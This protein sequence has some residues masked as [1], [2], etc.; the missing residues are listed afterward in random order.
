MEHHRKLACRVYQDAQ[1]KLKTQCP[2]CFA[3]HPILPATAPPSRPPPRRHAV[4]RSDGSRHALR[5]H[6]P[7]TDWCTM[8]AT[9]SAS[10][11]PSAS[12][13]PILVTGEHQ[14]WDADAPLDDRLGAARGREARRRRH[15]GR[16]NGR[17]VRAWCLVTDAHVLPAPG[18][19][20]ADYRRR[21][22]PGSWGRTRRGCCRR[23]TARPRRRL[24]TC[25]RARREG[26]WAVGAHTWVDG[27]GRRRVGRRR[28]SAWATC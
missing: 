16:P 18:G 13:A 23:S 8:R 12:S 6:A 11:A 17:A 1:Y 28:T 27:R 3:R 24:W 5:A 2:V 7:G 19:W 10:H 25:A 20:F 14:W 21:A 4:R 9:A 26:G 15:Q 22:T